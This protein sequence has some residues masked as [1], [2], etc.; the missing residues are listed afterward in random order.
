[1]SRKNL[2]DEPTFIERDYTSG[3]FNIPSDKEIIRRHLMKISDISAEEYVEGYWLKK[4]F[5]VGDGVTI[6]EEYQKDRR[7]AFINL[8]HFLIHMM[9][10]EFDDEI[11]E[12]EVEWQIE[13]DKERENHKADPDKSMS[14]W[15]DTKRDYYDKMLGEIF[16]LFNR[17]DFFGSGG[18]YIDE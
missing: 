13:L 10:P 3:D 6:I 15:I 7:K 18:V 17:I 16:L 11:K 8:V 14:D 5:K 9:R 2:D 1:M 12:K 4:P